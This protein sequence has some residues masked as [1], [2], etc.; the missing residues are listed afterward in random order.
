MAPTRKLPDISTLLHWRDDEHLTQADM[1]ARI[2]AT[3]GVRVSRGAISA[4]LSRAGK[5]TAK[6]RYV[7]CLPWRVG[8]AHLTEYPARMLRLLGRARAGGEL[9]EVEAA[10]L[11]NWLEVLQREDAVVGYDPD[12]AA[13]G[14]HYIDRRPGEGDDGIPIR[15]RRIHTLPRV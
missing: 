10:R 1:A 7:E 6:A 3:T 5:T 11:R 13:Q 15:R 9:P 14:F 4:A 12:N 8:T 2:Y